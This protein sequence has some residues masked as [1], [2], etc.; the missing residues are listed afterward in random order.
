MKQYDSKALFKLGYGLYVLTASDGLRLNGMI[1]NTVSQAASSP[2]LIAVSVNKANYTCEMILN[3]GKFNVN[4]L[5]EE[6]PFSVFRQ[7]GF[8]SG[9]DTDKFADEKAFCTKNGAPVLSKYI[10]AFISLEVVNS[11]DLGS[12]MLFI[13]KIEDA[14]VLNDKPSMTYAYYH[15][16]V[17]PKPEKTRKKGFVCKI[18]GY[19]YEGDVLPDDFICPIC[20][21]GAADFEPL[22]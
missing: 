7:F 19:I 3:G 20:K 9:R 17:K 1:C 11:L 12:H 18:C 2:E 22:E 6:A 21:H 5:T 14:A 13:C 15:S 16:R 8:C 4:C 10:N